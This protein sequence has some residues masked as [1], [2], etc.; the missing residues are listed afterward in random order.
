MQQTVLA[1]MW[2]CISGPGGRPRPPAPHDHSST[3]VTPKARKPSPCTAPPFRRRA[4]GGRVASRG[5]PAERGLPSPELSPFGG[6]H[7]III[8][9]S[10]WSESTMLC[11]EP[12]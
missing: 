6:C 3:A 7:P 1:V 4:N 10:L 11:F 2:A 9:G 5:G 8:V 12:F